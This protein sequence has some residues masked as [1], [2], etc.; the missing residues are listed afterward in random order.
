MDTLTD[1]LT[2][3]IR[4]LETIIDHVGAYVYTKDL[5]GRY[6]YANKM[7]CELFNRPLE[8][9]IG[10]TDE[11]F[12][13]LS[14]SNELRSNDRHVL[15]QGE[16]IESEETDITLTGETYIFWTV[17]LP[18]YSPDGSIVGMCGVSTDITERKKTEQAVHESEEKHRIMFMDSP[19]AYLI[20][21]DGLFVDCNRASEAMLRTDRTRIIGRTPDSLS[22]KF[23]PDGKE[24]S[25]SAKENIKEAFRNGSNTFEWVHR[26]LDGSDFF[27][28]VSI[29]PMLLEGKQTFFT[30]WRDITERKQA[31]QALKESKRA[32]EALSSTDG[33]TGI[34]NRRRFDEALSLEYARHTRS[35]AELSLIMLDIDHFKTFNDTY[36]HIAGDDCLRQ[37]GRVMADCASRSADLAARYGGEEF[38]CILP[39]T[40]HVG[41]VIIAERIRRAIQTLAIPH[42]ASETADCI[43]ASLGVVTMHCQ[44]EGS[45]INLIAQADELLYRAKSRGRNRVEFT[46]PD[47]HALAATA[48]IHENF[49]RMVWN[50]S[51]CCGNLLIDSQHQALFHLSNELLEAVLSGRPAA[52]SL[53][54]ITRLLDD[55]QQH[56]HDEEKILK[57]AGF[58]GIDRHISE[59]DKLLTKGVELSRQLSISALLIGNLFQFLAYDVVMA[60]MLGADREYYPFT[61]GTVQKNH[62]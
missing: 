17:K 6:T 20:I 22:P 13:N 50:D 15:D 31:E 37:I 55:V 10:A 35:G 30:C 46:V 27:V 33:L 23:Q 48:K 12:F 25:Q 2:A 40:D 41:A 44:T 47:D 39:E 53:V 58:P 51:F 24:S 29:A 34:A 36:G 16:Q 3:K 54:L 61:H 38:A 9:V 49:V 59:H 60:H 56:F 57:A 45:F 18:L 28:E 42:K 11:E 43:T 52:D 32:L 8:Q 7:V 19:D 26:R 5:A 4:Q 62:K 21:R 1:L 14:I